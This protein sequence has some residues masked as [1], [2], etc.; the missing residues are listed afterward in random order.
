MQLKKMGWFST[1]RDRAARLLLLAVE[2]KIQAGEIKN[3]KIEFVFS[4]REEGETKESDEFFRLVR[5]LKFSLIT[6]SSRKFK[7][8]LRRENVEKWREAYDREVIKRIKD[9]SP[10]F[11]VFS[12]YMLIVSPLLCKSFPIINLHPAAPGGP[13]GTWQEVIWELMEKRERE[14]GILIHRVTPELDEGPPLSFVRYSLKG[15]NFNSLWEEWKKKRGETSLEEIKRKEGE[16]EPLFQKIREEEVKREIP[17]LVQTI[18]AIAEGRLGFKSKKPLEL[19]QEV[20][21]ERKREERV[22]F[23]DCEGPLTVNDNALELCQ[24]FLPGGERFFTLISRWDDWLADIEKRKGYRPGTTLKFILPFLSAWE[25]TPEKMR[26]FSLTTLLFVPEAEKLL[27]KLKDFSSS[28]I[29]STSYEPYLEALS[30]RTRFPLLRMRFTTLEREFFDLSFY[31]REEIKKILEEILLLPEIDLKGAKKKE[32]L[33]PGARKTVKRLEEIFFKKLPSLPGVRKFFKRINPV[34]GEEKSQALSEFL[35]L[36][37]KDISSSLYIGDSITD[38]DPMRMVR[39]GGGLS[40]SFNGNRYAVREAEIV[41][42]SPDASPLIDLVELFLEEGKGKVLEWVKEWKRTSPWLGF[43]REPLEP[44]IEESERMR[45]RVR[46]KVR[47][48]LG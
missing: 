8:D 9:F 35:E 44:L 24:E 18:K 12:G 25:V 43:K 30:L 46:G 14:S 7:P 2:E 3:L 42:I 29:I 11:I 31:E 19:T 5:K 22:V 48:R 4:N 17:L 21:K 32:D 33:S 41:C 27:Q 26:E 36:R 13:K 23:L 37:G 45:K 10:D 28:F 47:G 16:K 34:G 1:G 38:Q 15:K 20:E 39:E 40:V 6:F